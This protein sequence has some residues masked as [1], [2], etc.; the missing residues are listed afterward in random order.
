M[1]V[2]RDRLALLRRVV[3]AVR[4]D[5]AAG[6]V[7]VVDDASSD[8]TAGWLRGADVTLVRCDG[9]GPG[10]ARQAGV[11]R[12]SGE[13][14]VLLDDD[15]V[16]RPGLVAGH[17]AELRRDSSIV[18][19]GYMPVPRPPRRRATDVAT[20]AYARD[21]ERRCSRYERGVAP[22]LHNLW[23]GNVGIWRSAAL[24]VGLIS[25]EFDRV[26]TFFEDRDFGLRAQRAGLRG[27]FDRSL[28]A[29]HHHRRDS[30]VALRDAAR[31]GECAVR[32]HRLHGEVLGP[33]AAPDVPR[34]VVRSP[35][36]ALAAALTA[37]AAAGRVGRWNVQDD[38]FK[39]ARRICELRGAMRAGA[40]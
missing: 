1:I 17:V 2:T 33:Y 39:V 9:V 38:A 5:P 21:Y 26:H 40:L 28:A 37:A 11:E 20:V 10:A 25:P 12:A 14:V 36:A 29:D 34:A 19:L 4:A 23:G 6:E 24:E 22:V 16:P 31:R 8:G 7:V 13:L 18:S 30:L 35:R 27:V 15:V 32:L 3:A